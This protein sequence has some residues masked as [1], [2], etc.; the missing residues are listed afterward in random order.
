MMKNLRSLGLVIVIIL[1]GLGCSDDPETPA[2]T[3][4]VGGTITQI[5][6]AQPVTDA[7]VHLIVQ[8]LCRGNKGPLC[9][10]RGR[11]LQSKSALATSGPACYECYLAHFVLNSLLASK[12]SPHTGGYK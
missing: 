4:S 8:S 11:I 5:E 6:T 7:R 10:K 1:V 9:T 3:G 12:K 2:A